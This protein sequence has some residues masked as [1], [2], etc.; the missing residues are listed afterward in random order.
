MIYLIVYAVGYTLVFVLI[1][2]LSDI[3]V[4]LKSILLKKDALMDSE[5]SD[6]EDDE[7]NF[8]IAGFVQITILFF[9]VAGLLQVKFQG[10]EA[11]QRFRFK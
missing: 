9:Q 3:I 4:W 5:E 7:G 6:E 8:S 10:G 2:N 1:T 11:K